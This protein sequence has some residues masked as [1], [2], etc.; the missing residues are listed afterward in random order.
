MTKAIQDN[1]YAALKGSKSVDEAVKDMQ[2]ALQ[3]ATSSGN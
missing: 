3:S 1:S 2:A